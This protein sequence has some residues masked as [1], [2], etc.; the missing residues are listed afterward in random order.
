[1]RNRFF[2]IFYSF[3]KNL[4]VEIVLFLLVFCFSYF[5]FNSHFYIDRP[6]SPD[7]T[8]HFQYSRLLAE[9]NTLRYSE[10]LNDRYGTHAFGFRGSVFN[11]GFLTHA[12]FHGFII[13]LGLLRKISESLLQIS[14]P[15][16]VLVS[17]VYF[18]RIARFFFD[19]EWSIWSV[20]LLNLSVPFLQHANSFNNNILA[21]CCFLGFFSHF[22]AWVFKKANTKTLVF[23]LIWF[24]LGF[25]TRI[26]FVVPVFLLVL[27]FGKEIWL[28]KKA[29]ARCD[30]GVTLIL[31]LLFLLPF[32]WVN[33]VLYEQPL[34]YFAP[35]IHLAEYNEGIIGQS[36]GA[37]IME[38]IIQFDSI[39]VIKNF[40]RFVVLVS[41]VVTIT[42]FSYLVFSRRN[43]S[44]TKLSWVFLLV[45]LFYFLNEWYGAGFTQISAA[46]SYLR[47]LMPVWSI[48]ILIF[49]YQLRALPVRRVFKLG[50]ISLLITG[51]ILFAVFGKFGLA[52]G[53]WYTHVLAENMS[54]F[55]IATPENAIFLTR[56]LD[57]F[58]FPLR[59]NYLYG[60]ISPADQRYC[61]VPRQLLQDG[62]PL[63]IER[64][65]EHLPF[66]IKCGLEAETDYSAPFVKITR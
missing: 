55:V 60:S 46:T 44:L 49:V 25:W 22:Y 42:F 62:Y 31:S 34:G 12:S 26:D 54:D 11:Q 64:E 24:W 47:Y 18:Y 10:P 23:A 7:M 4:S 57:K 56:K 36:A 9:N 14:V 58:V 15:L 39:A 5:V 6:G 61:D 3:F 38:F 20:L 16:L 48:V 51:E 28:K 21:A 63:Y 19:R 53:S 37:K 29:I 32:A 52:Y 45:V 13:Y 41:P 50:I 59:K 27:L 35:G 40:Y 1:M 65:P 8:I 33:Q 66:L 30:I 17:S 43:P 2:I